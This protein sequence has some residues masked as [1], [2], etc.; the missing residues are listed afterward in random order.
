MQAHLAALLHPYVSQHEVSSLFPR[1]CL[2]R[3]L[4]RPHVALARSVSA[5][6]QLVTLSGSVDELSVNLAFSSQR[7][8][9]A[10]LRL[11][12]KLASWARTAAD[13]HAELVAAM[14]RPAW[15]APLLGRLT[16]AFAS[17]AHV[18]V[19]LEDWI[20]QIEG[21]VHGRS[22]VCALHLARATLRVDGGRAGELALDSVAVYWESKPLSFSSPVLTCPRPT[23]AVL[24][25][26]SVRVA[27]SAPTA[28]QLAAVATV[29][30]RVGLSFPLECVADIAALASGD[31]PIVAFGLD[32]SAK[33]LWRR[34]LAAVR[35][36]RRARLHRQAWTHL[37]ASLKQAAVP[38]TMRVIVRAEVAD[39]GA[40]VL[41]AGLRLR[42]AGLALGLS[43]ATTVA[44]KEASGHVDDVEFVRVDGAVVQASTA[45]DARTSVDVDACRVVLGAAT[46]LQQAAN[47]VASVV[48]DSAPPPSS[49]TPPSSEA[50]ST[51]SRA[52]HTRVGIG[53]MAWHAS[54]DSPGQAWE[55]CNADV[56]VEADGSL[57][58]S[59]AVASMHGG[60]VNARIAIDAS[61]R[62]DVQASVRGARFE[63][64]LALVA[65][66][67]RAAPDAV[68]APALQS[69]PA[70][71]LP[72]SVPELR[73]SVEV[74]GAAVAAEGCEL[75][76]S[77]SVDVQR[78]FGFA[79]CDSPR[80][81]DA[82]DSRKPAT[83]DDDDD[84][85]Y[86]AASE[87]ASA[88]V[89]ARAVAATTRAA[90]V[91]RDTRLMA[92]E[93]CVLRASQ[94]SLALLEDE[95]VSSVQLR[96]P[97]PVDA[98]L[99]PSR[100]QTLARL[101][102]ALSRCFDGPA[103]SPTPLHVLPVVAVDCSI[104]GMRLALE[105]DAA[106]ALSWAGVDVQGSGGGAFALSG[107]EAR[108]RVADAEPVWLGGWTAQLALPL[109]DGDALALTAKLDG[110]R[111]ALFD[112]QGL[113]DAL[114]W[115]AA[116]EEAKPLQRPV[117]TPLSPP[118]LRV[119][120]AL[121]GV[122]LVVAADATTD[123]VALHVGATVTAESTASTASANV[124]LRMS[125]EGVLDAPFTLRAA[126]KRGGHLRR[127][128]AA[129]DASVDVTASPL[130]AN[131]ELNR[132]RRL[133]APSPPTQPPTR[134]ASLATG[135][136]SEAAPLRLFT[137]AASVQ[138]AHLSAWHV[139]VVVRPAKGQ[140]AL[141]R[142]AAAMSGR[143]VRYPLHG[144]AQSRADGDAD[145]RV[146]VF[147][148]V[149]G[150]WEPVV[151]AWPLKLAVD[152]PALRSSGDRDGGKA[153]GG[154]DDDE[155]EAPA[156]LSVS[157]ASSK[158]L[159]VSVTP[160]LARAYARAL[161]ATADDGD[162][163]NTAPVAGVRVI[164]NLL[165]VPIC[166]SAELCAAA[167]RAGETVAR[168]W[169]EDA[170]AWARR[171]VAVRATHVRLLRDP[172]GQPDR[173]I[174]LV[175]DDG[176]LLRLACDADVGAAERRAPAQQPQHVRALQ[177]VCARQG[178]V[179]RAIAES[180]E[181]K[182]RLVG[183]LQRALVA[184][185]DAGVAGALGGCEG[186]LVAASMPHWPA[187]TP[188]RCHARLRSG[189]LE[190]RA[191]DGEAGEQLLGALDMADVAAVSRARGDEAALFLHVAIGDAADAIATLRVGGEVLWERALVEAAA[192]ARSVAHRVSGA[193]TAD[194]AADVQS[195]AGARKV[196]PGSS[197]RFSMDEE[198][199]EDNDSD[200]DEG[201]LAVGVWDGVAAF[202]ELI[203]VGREPT[204]SPAGVCAVQSGGETV[205]Q[206]RFVLINA[207]GEA[208]RVHVGRVEAWA[209]GD[210]VD[211][212][213]VAL[214]GSGN[215]GA[216]WTLLR[217]GGA[218]VLDAREGISG[219]GEDA[220]AHVSCGA[221]PACDAAP[222]LRG[223]GKVRLEGVFAVR[224]AIAV[225][226]DA[227][228]RFALPWLVANAAAVRVERAGTAA[229]RWAALAAP[230]TQRGPARR[231][232][233]LED[234]G[235][236]PALALAC[237]L[238]QPGFWEVAVR[239]LLS[240]SNLLPVDVFADGAVVR[241]GE[242]PRPMPGARADDAV[243]LSLRPGSVSHGQRRRLQ[244]SNP[245]L[246]QRALF[247]SVSGRTLA[248]EVA[249]TQLEDG[250]RASVKDV[251]DDN[252]AKGDDG[253]G[254]VEFVFPRAESAP[255]TR[256]V[257]ARVWVRNHS[258]QA[259]LARSGGL[260]AHVEPGALCWVPSNK[261][262][263][264]ELSG[265][266]DA[267]WSAPFG[268]HAQSS[269]AVL[270]PGVPALRLGVSVAACKGT[271]AAWSVVATVVDLYVVRNALPVDIEVSWDGGSSL[272]ARVPAGGGEAACHPPAQREEATQ[273]RAR[274]DGSAWSGA[275]DLNAAADARLVFA[276]ARRTWQRAHCANA[277]WTGAEAAADA[278][279]VVGLRVESDGPGQRAVVSPAASPAALRVCV[280]NQTAAA[281]VGAIEVGSCAA[282]ARVFA[283]PGEKAELVPFEPACSCVR[284]SVWGAPLSI[285]PVEDIAVDLGAAVG[286]DFE[287]RGAFVWRVVVEDGEKRVEIRDVPAREDDE[288]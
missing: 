236:E 190:L 38:S 204:A 129:N 158:Q 237:S 182:E 27:L 56:D 132:W 176:A 41:G 199:E 122:V 55:G 272:G 80:S 94:V 4:L 277:L 286:G 20:I 194:K 17:L 141:L 24:E 40:E 145:V 279:W 60:S 259:L 91:L 196:G 114:A 151:A 140:P 116:P 246:M 219:G 102:R 96:Q 115:P 233:A 227:G 287:R 221:A 157:L 126:L 214:G 121:A 88:A 282:P 74:D 142:V 52:S 9:V 195:R 127:N 281:R 71:L 164:R 108:L 262:D 242:E 171:W 270:A 255:V 136:A 13:V 3:L 163:C 106:G 207:T 205:L 250:L 6:L 59:C 184:L 212:Y 117:P 232:I 244:R 264:L 33:A 105:D 265:E 216:A 128:G 211:A 271:A 174:G 229:T 11:V 123:D 107:R 15:W 187:A 125:A 226:L 278:G 284:V 86:D 183:A 168:A 21:A 218:Q 98:T 118:P 177:L 85:F 172:G 120:L 68:P 260:V 148:T 48:R 43:D 249:T 197:A 161:R 57:R 201:V 78:E 82:S 32:R 131:V 252:D 167:A 234:D 37:L 103:P 137:P 12:L 92:G 77:C 25:P 66:W 39:V 83:G 61:G 245:S 152:S 189:V 280:A 119:S 26:L 72:A 147:N 28:N 263:T 65:L 31:Q 222:V 198:G 238:A 76:L 283:R 47:L 104:A 62:V 150:G 209:P 75:V 170:G 175:G 239:A 67:T 133:L 81:N 224:G 109:H 217:A 269:G 54:E 95:T 208:I 215:G 188:R 243:R 134:A 241:S 70:S 135:G 5:A 285:R 14:Q 46:R 228:A 34:A 159:A 29:A 69:R 112:A 261:G 230:L 79:D 64:D 30:S 22:F 42:V 44:F 235:G 87:P 186:L 73:A 203:R 223:G 58:V 210:C 110:A 275:F 49:P 248:R 113:A 240:V 8:R 97:V 220:V 154:F 200:D 185:A 124:E 178:R 173:I 180:A 268:L 100:S 143:A 160:S 155:H 191:H 257:F 84:D 93:L 149:V 179:L 89:L 256:T 130:N 251:A 153:D 99:G 274:V 35:L 16:R 144:Q 19:D 2:R 254:D 202:P 101:V 267:A 193:A 51:A 276:P 258:R 266:G 45:A 213:A 253:D 53:A 162:A 63:P 111:L 206:S 165:G 139:S 36:R 247:K 1:L 146:D 225:D 23:H 7:A 273:W 18:E 10:K 231:R 50:A 138:C 288:F 169:V 166:V 192:A 156:L 90:V 181:A